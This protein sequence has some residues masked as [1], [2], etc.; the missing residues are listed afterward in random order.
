VLVLSGEFL[1]TGQ[2]DTIPVYGD[3]N[4]EI[5]G[6]SAGGSVDLQRKLPDSISFKTVETITADCSKRGLEPEYGTVYRFDCTDGGG[7]TIKYRLSKSR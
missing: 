4:I 6:I 3:F 5:T 1:A 7:S 2:S